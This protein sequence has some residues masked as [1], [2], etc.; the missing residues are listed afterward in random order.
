MFGETYSS[1][2][3]SSTSAPAGGSAPAIAG[4]G[5]ARGSLGCESSCWVAVPAA[6]H[7]SPVPARSEAGM[8]CTLKM[9]AGGGGVLMPATYKP[10][11]INTESF[12]T[13]KN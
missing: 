1:S 5:A 10:R 4:A 9:G 2:D 6:V 12:P 3:D 7:S 8:S 11:I 13:P